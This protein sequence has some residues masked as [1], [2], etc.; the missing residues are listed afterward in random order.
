MVRFTLVEDAK[1]RNKKKTLSSFGGLFVLRDLW[2]KF[3]VDELLQ[4]LGIVKN[5]G[6]LTASE[7]AFL[8]MSQS[9]VGAGSEKD[10]AEKASLSGNDPCLCRK[11]V[12]QKVLN[13]FF[14][15]GRFDFKELFTR[16][17]LGILSHRKIH[18]M[19]RKNPG[20]NILVVDDSPLEKSGKRMQGISKL[21]NSSKKGFYQGFEMVALTMSAKKSAFLL[22]FMLKPG[23]HKPVVKKTSAK[24][25]STT[26]LTLAADMIA[27]AIA[28]GIPARMVTF[29]LWYT[30]VSFLEKMAALNLIFVAPLKKNRI[31]LYQGKR[32]KVTYFVQ[33]CQR[34]N[35]WGTI[36][37]VDLPRFGPVRLAAFKRRL[38]N[39]KTCIEILITN[40]DKLSSQR[41]LSIYQKRWTIE[42]LFREAKQSFGLE[43]FHNQNHHAT[44][45]HLCFSL[46]AMLFIRASKFLFNSLQTFTPGAIKKQLIQTMVE[47]EVNMRQWKIT[48]YE[49]KE[50]IHIFKQLN[51]AL[52]EV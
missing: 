43:S 3:R 21:Y 1:N 4:T 32:K 24:K 35:E 26:K 50:F 13:R 42:T 45:A 49:K 44:V 46:I 18:R 11:P 51:L 29:D 9:M 52:E 8:S 23:S 19:I 30:A 12:P 20:K 10:L 17:V 2:K 15:T 48:F 41:M 25:S 36:F 39:K 40:G 33:R 6:S 27:Q 31:V 28:S 22:D 7:L 34:T 14:N 38:K 47:I 37:L 5:A 16:L